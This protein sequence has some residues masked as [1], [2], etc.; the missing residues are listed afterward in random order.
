MKR[1]FTLLSVIFVLSLTAC[2]KDIVPTTGS[3]YGTVYDAATGEIVN[4]AL[5]TL[6][7][8][9]NS[10]TTASDGSFQFIDISADKYTLQCS[11]DGYSPRNQTVMVYADSSNHCDMHLS[12]EPMIEGFTL[13]TNTLNFD[14]NETEKSFSIRNNGNSGDISWSIGTINVS[15]LNVDPTM[16]VTSQGQQSSIKVTI[17]RSKITKDESTTLIIEAGGGS[18]SVALYVNSGKNS[19]NG[20]AYED[21]SSVKTNI[22]TENFS[23]KV[24][25]CKRSGNSVKMEYTLTNN[26]FYSTSWSIDSTQCYASDNLYNSYS[27]DMLAHT[28]STKTGGYG[29]SLYGAPVEAYQTVKGSITVK[30]ADPSAKELS[31]YLKNVSFGGDIYGNYDISM[32]NVPIY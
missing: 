25:R 13:S 15:W 8:I 26:T 10:V 27:W 1:L 11:A 17:N 4:N 2:S 30:V 18:K 14:S 28:L 3:I 20:S 23:L 22:D 19:G 16:G 7:P 9:G 32:V 21:Y 12:K 24:T 31:F 6:L 5:V 29:S